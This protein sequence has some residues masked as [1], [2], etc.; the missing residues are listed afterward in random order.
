MEVRVRSDIKVTCPK[1]GK[2][3][4]KREKAIPKNELGDKMFICW[5]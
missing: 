2:N 1:R 4:R 5:K 3:R